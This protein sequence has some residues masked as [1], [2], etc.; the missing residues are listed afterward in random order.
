MVEMDLQFVLWIFLINDIPEAKYYPFPLDFHSK[1]IP[2]G[3]FWVYKAEYITQ[4]LEWEKREIPAAQRKFTNFDYNLEA[5]LY[6]QTPYGPNEKKTITLK[7]TGGI[8]DY[9]ILLGFAPIAWDI[10]KLNEHV[11]RFKDNLVKKIPRKCTITYVFNK[12]VVRNLL[13]VLSLVLSYG[14]S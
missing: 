4:A 9:F 12:I 6:R 3:P 11:Q 5:V 14:Q 2:T 8:L 7:S 1:K 13:T 10:A